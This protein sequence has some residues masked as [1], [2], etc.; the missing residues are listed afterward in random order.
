VVHIHFLL[1]SSHYEE[2]MPKI[3]LS[4]ALKS[5]E[6]IV[7]GAISLLPNFLITLVIVCGFLILGSAFKSMVRRV[8]ERAS[9]IEIL[10]F[11]SDS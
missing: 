10:P 9:A 2:P 1:L 6:K 8:L 5:G 3:D 4:N 7:N 11:S